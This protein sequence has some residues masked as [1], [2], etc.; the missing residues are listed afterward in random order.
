[1]KC[2]GRN[3]SG[4]LGDG[5]TV[6]RDVPVSVVGLSGRVKQVALGDSHT[7]ALL[8]TGAVECWGADWDGRL[9]DGGTKS[10]AVPVG[11]AAL[12]SE[13]TAI[14]AGAAHTCAVTA[15]GAV[16]CWGRN[17]HGELGDGSTTGSRVPISVTHLG[18]V[19]AVSAGW[20]HT[21]ALTDWGGVLCWGSNRNGQL[22]DGSGT[23]SRVPVYLSDLTGARVLGSGAEHSCVA[24]QDGL[25]PRCWGDPRSGALGSG[26]RSG[27]TT[28]VAVRGLPASAK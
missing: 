7:C 21:C 23:N 25:A 28:P 14:G 2:W 20:L 17:S 12:A 22:G 3:S 10:S 18:S 27:G 16:K 1:V 15:T 6:G 19:R 8:D 9:G 5:T 4:E 13:V 24:M 26:S 11:V